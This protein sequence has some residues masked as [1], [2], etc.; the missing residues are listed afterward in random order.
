MDINEIDLY[1]LKREF[2][3]THDHKHYYICF[4]CRFERASKIA[5]LEEVTC[6]F[7]RCDLVITFVN[8]QTQFM[9]LIMGSERELHLLHRFGSG[10]LNSVNR[11]H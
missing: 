10:S 9:I 5:N 8:T 7:S 11:L 6:R 2:N 1:I 3:V 4:Y